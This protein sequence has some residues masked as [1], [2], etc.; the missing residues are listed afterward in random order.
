VHEKLG[1]IWVHVAF[2]G[3]EEVWLLFARFESCFGVIGSGTCSWQGAK[4]VVEVYWGAAV[5]LGFLLMVILRLWYVVLKLLRILGEGT[6]SMAKCGNWQVEVIW[7]KV[8]E[9]GEDAA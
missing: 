8:N 9:W 2:L 3:I 5:A 1:G 7:S 6:F 4:E